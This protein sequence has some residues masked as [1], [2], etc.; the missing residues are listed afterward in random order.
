MTSIEGL[1]RENERL[2]HLLTCDCCC[3]EKTEGC[4]CLNSDA[5]DHGTIVGQRT[6]FRRLLQSHG[7]SVA[8]LAEMR[9]LAETVLEVLNR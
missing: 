9:Q 4:I 3:G 5:K 8:R 2:K 6:G 7:V 1:T